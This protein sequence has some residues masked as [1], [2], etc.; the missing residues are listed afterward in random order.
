M[1]TFLWRSGSVYNGFMKRKLRKILIIL[2]SVCLIL[3]L[4]VSALLMYLNKLNEVPLSSELAG[5]Y[6]VHYVV[7]GDTFNALID[8][9]D[10]RIRI[11]GVDTPESVSS[12]EADNTPE[13]EKAA[14]FLAGLLPEGTSVWLEYGTE[15][16]DRYGRTLA[17]VYLSE[18]GGIDNMVET[19]L[20]ANGIARCLPVE[21]NTRYRNQFA[22]IEAEAK[23]HGIGFWAYDFW[24]D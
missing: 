12:E 9:N 21:P 4:A 22:G 17:Y 16:I 8:G 10:T 14:A 20:L 7:D 15:K 2:L 5:P 24:K 18:A 1:N 13:G 3:G 6:K 19:R 23:K 11:I